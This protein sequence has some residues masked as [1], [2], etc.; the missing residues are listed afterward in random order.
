M[1]AEDKEIRKLKSNSTAVI[2]SSGYADTLMEELSVAGL[3]L[4]DTSDEIL[5][6]QITW[7]LV[8]ASPNATEYEVAAWI[9]DGIRRS[10]FR[11]KNVG[12]IGPKKKK[13]KK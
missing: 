6:Q 8:D 5:R 1:S 4:V 10:Q 11:K 13:V 7:I 3:S 12:I 2:A 9:L